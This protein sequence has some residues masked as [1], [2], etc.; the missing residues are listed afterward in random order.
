M[1]YEIPLD[2]C[3]NCSCC[4]CHHYTSSDAAASGTLVYPAL[5]GV[6]SVA[7]D[8]PDAAE[9]LPLPLLLNRDCRMCSMR[10]NMVSSDKYL[11]SV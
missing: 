5:L 1:Q 3:P 8:P 7:V 6:V 2:D 9:A 4:C 11:S 10:A